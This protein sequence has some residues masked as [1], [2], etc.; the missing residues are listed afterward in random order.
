M[1]VHARSLLYIVQNVDTK[2]RK[3]FQITRGIVK[4]F[5]EMCKL[6]QQ[7]NRPF[8]QYTRAARSAE[9]KCK[10]LKIFDN[11]PFG[12]WQK[13]KKKLVVCVKRARARVC[14]AMGKKAVIC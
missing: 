3:Y 8:L 11:T 9:I 6:Q 12:T 1:Y 2:R 13:K 4:N 5:T 7:R 14:A 10:K